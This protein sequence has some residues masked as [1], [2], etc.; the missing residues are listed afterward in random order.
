MI[1][2]R[3]YDIIQILGAATLVELTRCVFT[4]GIFEDLINARGIDLV[5]RRLCEDLDNGSTIDSDLLRLFKV[6]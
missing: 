5:V 2:A 3:F 6:F 4:K 1:I